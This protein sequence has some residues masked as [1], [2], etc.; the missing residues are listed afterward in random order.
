MIIAAEAS[1]SLYAQRLLELWRA[2]GL[3]IDAFG[4]GSRD[5][6]KLGFECLGRSEEMA[7]VGIQEVVK[8][9]PL[10]RRVFYGLLA[11]SRQT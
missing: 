10:I 6:E 9:F 2:K 4:I 7:V 3:Q 11:R 5:M 1:S 8:H